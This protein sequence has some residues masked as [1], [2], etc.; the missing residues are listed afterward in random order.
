MALY[1]LWVMRSYADVDSLFI[2]HTVRFIGLLPGGLEAVDNARTRNLRMP[3]H[4][5][6][7]LVLELQSP[8]DSPLSLWARKR[9][10]VLHAHRATIIWLESSAPLV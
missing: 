8:S 1:G 7:H 3:T 5:G 2:D 9:T 6:L 10:E 4:V